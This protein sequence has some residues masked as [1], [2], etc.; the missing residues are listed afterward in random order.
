M[1]K[2]VLYLEKNMK[3]FISYSVFVVFSLLLFDRC[4]S[5]ASD[6][7]IIPPINIPD[8]L[9]NVTGYINSIDGPVEDAN[10]AL[11]NKTTF[12][13]S[14]GFFEFKDCIKKNLELTIVHPEY[15]G[16]TNSINVTDSLDL[17]INLTR[18]K[19]DYFPLKVGNHWT[20]HWS[21]VWYASGGGG[22]NS[23]GTI[24][25]EIV[26]VEGVYPNFVYKLKETRF[27][28]TYN[29]STEKYLDI[30]TNLSDSIKVLDLGYI[31]KSPV[32]RRYY[33]TS[34]Q[35]TIYVFGY[36]NSSLKL[37]RM[38]GVINC[39]YGMGGIT[40]GSFTNIE[41]LSYDLQ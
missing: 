14:S 21:N 17:D 16:Y 34:Y 20:Y 37:K 35:D 11:N 9:G 7:I 15:G 19:Y 3:C 38:I 31:L 40:Y 33:P 30:Q 32:I 6:D 23:T 27:D 41:I 1:K 2:L 12:S 29:S 8:T 10:I 4:N 25:W 18:I 22:G 24:D 5:N 28:S 13:D 26:N 36:E 39:N